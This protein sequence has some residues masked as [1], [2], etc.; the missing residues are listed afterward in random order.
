MVDWTRVSPYDLFD[1]CIAVHPLFYAET[2]RQY[3]KKMIYVSCILVDEFEKED[4]KAKEMM[5]F[6]INTPGVAKADEVIVQSETIRE[7][8]ITSLTEWAG[9]ESRRKWEEKIKTGGLT[10]EEFDLYPPVKD[11]ELSEEWME[12]LYNRD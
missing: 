7:R 6:C 12:V 5:K 11:E 8:Y 4:F 2:I 10:S 1:A 3:A 9:E